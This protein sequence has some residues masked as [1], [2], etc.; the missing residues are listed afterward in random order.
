LSHTSRF[1]AVSCADGFLPLFFPIFIDLNQP[2]IEDPLDLSF[3]S[4]P[5]DEYE[6]PAN[7]KPPSLVETVALR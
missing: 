7:K 4:N 1:F 6:V 2:D 3:L 5:K